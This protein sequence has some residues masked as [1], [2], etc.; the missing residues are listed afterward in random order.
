MITKFVHYNQYPE[1]MV[2]IFYQFTS[3]R[4]D[5]TLCLYR[6]LCISHNQ[7]T[8]PASTVAALQ[9]GLALGRLRQAPS[10]ADTADPE[11]HISLN[12]ALHGLL[13]GS[14]DPL[15][16][17]GRGFHDCNGARTRADSVSFSTAE[18]GVYRTLTEVCYTPCD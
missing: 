1:A 6:F 4:L 14:V 16:Q 7:Q 2:R 15:A 3:Q 18:I 5:G 11:A 13:F 9:A 10:V 12:A 8:R 17:A